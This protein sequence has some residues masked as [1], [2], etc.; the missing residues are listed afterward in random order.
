MILHYKR[1]A[2]IKLPDNII[3]QTSLFGIVSCNDLKSVLFTPASR[4]QRDAKL[5]DFEPLDQVVE[6]LCQLGQFG[7]A[8]V[9]IIACRIDFI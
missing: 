8:V 5:S 1:P 9:H 3:R 2:D 6:L 7:R 4:L